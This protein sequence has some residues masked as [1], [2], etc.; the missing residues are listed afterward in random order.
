LLSTEIRVP[1]GARQ[2]H[3]R[4]PICRFVGPS[5][6]TPADGEVA[7]ELIGDFAGQDAE[8]P[9]RDAGGGRPHP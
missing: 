5:G 6:A 1:L 9:P 7:V 8:G 3:A 2:K 4:R